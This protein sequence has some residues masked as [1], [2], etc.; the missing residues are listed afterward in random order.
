MRRFRYWW[1]SDVHRRQFLALTGALVTGGLLSACGDPRKDRVSFLNWQDYIDPALL[2]DFE[3]A[4][5]LTVGYETYASNDELGDRLALAG[6]RRRGGRKSTSFDLIV[7][8]D[9]LFRRFRDQD[10]LQRLD[11]SVVTEAL[12]GNLAQEFRALDVDPGNR[13]AVPWATG[14][15]GIGYD[16]TVF[17]EPPDWSVF[18]DAS[19]AG[20]VSV[21]DETRE[22][23]A[24]ALYLLGEDPNTTDS[25]IIAKAEETLVAIR[26][27]AEFDS[28]TY[29]DRLADGQL[30]AAQG[31]SSD[32]LQARTRNPNIAFVIPEAGGTRWIDLLCIPDDAPNPDGANRFI[33]YMLDPKVAAANAVAIQ[34]DTGNEAARAFLPADVLADP[35][36]S[37]P[38]ELAARLSFLRDLGDDEALYVEA[39]E[40]VRG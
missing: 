31:F 12:L 13:F 11:S 5:G 39:W 3:A 21:L 33:A 40:R 7:P 19:Q 23:F 14:T 1:W 18:T 17:P 36:I 26:N 6:V 28:A 29:L 32:V 20:K 8:S 22:A 34:A 4:T 30:V 15:T 9:N 2:A 37:P 38:A 25:A 24:A 35:A 10:R 27:V 16:T